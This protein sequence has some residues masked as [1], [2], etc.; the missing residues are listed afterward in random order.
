MTVTS[1]R[2]RPAIPAATTVA[3]LLVGG[4]LALAALSL[5]APSIPSYDPFAW[6]VW[7][8]ELVKPGQTFAMAGGPSW[9]PLPVLF[10]APFALAGSAA[11]S[12]WLLVART[13]ALLALAGAFAL[14][15]RLAG[16]W[17]G[18]VAALGVLLTEEFASLAWRGASEPL[19]IAC[20]LW[21]AERHLAGRR[22]TAFALGVAAALI[23]P[24][25]WPFLILYALW[26]WRQVERTERLAMLGGLLLVPLLWVGPP[27]VAGDPFAASSHA[28]NYNG[29][30]GSNPGWTALKRGLGLALAPLWVAAAAAVALRP[31]DRPVRGLALG[32]V[33]WLALVVV[34]TIAGYP[35]LA[36]FM[37]P[38][39]AL[40]CALA[41]VGAVELV[42]R[43]AGAGGTALAALAATAL[44]GIGVAFAVGPARTAVHDTRAAIDAARLQ[45]QLS[46]A[47]AAAGGRKAVFAC[48]AVAVNHTAQ[49]ALA[50]KLDVPLDRVAL[51]LTRPGIVFRGPQSVA[52]GAPPPVVFPPPWRKVT[53]AHVGVWFVKLVLPG[54]APPPPGCGRRA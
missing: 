28:A 20:V 37:L 11:P 25:A 48:G 29:N 12:L 53:I 34:M 27:A 19:L 26:R 45:H 31:R 15:T 16:A 30:T 2:S 54:H 47:I 6:I 33:A 22:G 40:A 49:T 21:A 42:R 35:G 18:L 17:A 41:G 23:R 7:G 46:R 24:E 51:Q 50:W 52:L 13:G 5:L 43:A 9:K 14:G 32:A 1:P 44:L 10:T 38:S 36:R 8:R 39:A 4:A 3:L